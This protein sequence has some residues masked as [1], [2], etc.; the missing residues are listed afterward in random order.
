MSTQVE[1]LLLDSNSQW[2]STAIASLSQ[3]Y[4]CTYSNNERILV[5]ADNRQ[6]LEQLDELLWHNSSEQF[7]P[8]SLDSECYSSSAAVLLTNTQPEKVRYQVALN[9]GSKILINPEQFRTIIEIV[10][11]DDESKENARSRYKNYRQLGFPISHRQL[12]KND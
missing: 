11:V 7:I 5:L 1:F 6:Y 12:T 9:I 2:I 3:F 10:N 4:S 8:Y